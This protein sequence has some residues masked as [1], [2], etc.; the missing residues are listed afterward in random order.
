MESMNLENRAIASSF[1][2]RCKKWNLTADQQEIFGD[3]VENVDLI[4][5]KNLTFTRMEL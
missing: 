3:N 2:G 4:Y 5:K 1:M